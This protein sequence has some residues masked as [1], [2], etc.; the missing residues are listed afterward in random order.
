MFRLALVISC[1]F[2][3]IKFFKQLLADVPSVA[4]KLSEQALRH[5]RHRFT[6]ISVSRGELERQQFSALVD[7]QM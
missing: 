2:A 3:L 6:V 5:L 7:D 4:K 1:A